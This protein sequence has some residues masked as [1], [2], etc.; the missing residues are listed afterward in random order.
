MRSNSL[1]RRSSRA[2]SNRIF[3]RSSTGIFQPEF[4]M[5][6]NR[7]TT[8]FCNL[9]GLF[10]TQRS[11]V[12]F[13]TDAQCCPS[14]NGLDAAPCLPSRKPA[15]SARRCRTL[16]EGFCVCRITGHRDQCRYGRW[17]DLVRKM[18][19]LA[20]CVSQ[21]KGRNRQCASNLNPPEPCSG[22]RR[23]FR[24]SLWWSAISGRGRPTKQGLWSPSHPRPRRQ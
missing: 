5:K 2:G 16:S 9:S 20:K 8:T 4:P 13:G 24:G 17:P 10:G 11:I 19:F 18:A 23:P 22:I 7:V 1:S 3:S 6:E 12:I 14:V 15:G 21:E